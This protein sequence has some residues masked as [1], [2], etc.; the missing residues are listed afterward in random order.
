MHYIPAKEADFIDWS[1]NLITVSEAHIV[2]WN[3]P[4]SK[5]TELRTLHTE[6]KRLHLL[7][8]TPFHTHADLEA[9]NER[10]AALIRLEEVFVR[11]NLQNN[12]LMTDAGREEV[13]IPIH[14]KIRTLHGA[15]DEVPDVEVLTP[16]PRTVRVRFRAPNAPRWGK[17]KYAHGIE[18]LWAQLDTPPEKVAD[19]LHLA[20]STNTPLDLVFDEDRRG[21]RIYFAVRWERGA[22]KKGPWSAI[23]SAFVP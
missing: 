9:K 4:P 10:K 6:V 7:C 22:D 3:L 18:C 21:K 11:N 16:L 13:Q 20:F 14:D 19:L 1:E 8:K 17:P 5:V 23:F 2:E 12:D 15:P